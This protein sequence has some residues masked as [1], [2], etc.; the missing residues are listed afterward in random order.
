MTLV[1]V[2]LDRFR[3]S[4]RS[5][6]CSRTRRQAVNPLS[7]LVELRNCL[8]ADLISAAS[9]MSYCMLN[10]CTLILLV[11][12]TLTLPG[13]WLVLPPQSREWGDYYNCASRNFG[14]LFGSFL[15]AEV[16]NDERR[17]MILGVGG[18][19]QKSYLLLVPP[20]NM[21]GI[22]HPDCDA[23]ELTLPWFFCRGG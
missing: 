22:D 8:V 16:R 11:H 13:Q 12:A 9:H 19:R 1:R 7:S 2:S 15:F 10:Y 6:S 4:R 5:R 18:I 23:W 14:A 3:P 21:G 17:L 20:S